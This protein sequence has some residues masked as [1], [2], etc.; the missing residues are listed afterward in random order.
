[1]NDLGILI[2]PDLKWN[3]HITSICKKARKHLGL[4]TRTLSYQAPTLAKKTACLALVRSIIEYGSPLWSPKTKALLNQVERVQRKMTNF[5]TNNARYDS[6]H[7][8]DYKTRLLSL[9]LLPTSFRREITDLTLFLK[10]IHN[11]TNLDITD[12]IDFDNRQ[13]GARTRS[14][15][16]Q[17]RLRIQKTRLGSTSTFFTYRI[18]KI[19]NNLPTDLRIALK[20]TYNPLIIKQHLIPYYRQ[21]LANDF[22]PNNQ[23]TWISWCGCGR[24]AP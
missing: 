20:N 3:S 1:M 22:D 7:H 19:W 6:P 14:L 10:S 17:T 21:R 24:C 13:T 12:Y 9:N 16:H 2:T 11:K 4:V 8:I 23:C 15:D 18:C 5:I